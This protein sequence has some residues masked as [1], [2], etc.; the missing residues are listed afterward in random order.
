M[1]WVA[2]DRAHRLAVKRALPAPLARWAQIRDAI[3]TDILAHFWDPEQKAFVQSRGS[4]ALDGST[5]LLTNLHF[6]ASSDPRWRSTLQAIEAQLVEEPFV[7]RY[8]SELLQQ[9]DMAGREGA[10]IAC[11]FWYVEALARGGQVQKARLVFERMLGYANH[12]GLYAEEL[13]EFG[14]QL[15]NFPQALSHLTLIMAALTLD[16]ALSKE[17]LPA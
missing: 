12:L 4:K 6:L 8:R 1:C 14:E 13:G 2:L 11:S 9:D 16:R 10:F 5:F 3:H 15:G 17:P 7:Y